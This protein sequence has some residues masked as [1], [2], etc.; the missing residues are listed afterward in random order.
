M[1]STKRDRDE[2]VAS[3]PDEK[4]TRAMDTVSSTARVTYSVRSPVELYFFRKLMQET[5]FPIS[6]TAVDKMNVADENKHREYSPMRG[7]RE[8]SANCA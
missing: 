1:A 5:L 7:Q 2:V 3:P 6:D 8:L 4:R